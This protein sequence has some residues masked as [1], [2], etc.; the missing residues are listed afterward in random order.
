MTASPADIERAAELLVGGGV[1]AF[2]TE[3]VYGVGA[4]ATDEDAVE[5]IFVMKGRPKTRPLIVH[6]AEADQVDQFASEVPDYARK[7]TSLWPGPLTIVLNRR[8]D[9]LDVVTGGGDTVAVRIP[10]HDVALKMLRRVRELGGPQAGVAAPSAN[11]FGEPPPTSVQGVIDGLGRP[12]V[13][14]VGTPDMILDGGECPGGVPSTIVS[15]VGEWP[16][17]LRYGALDRA[18]IEDCIGRFVDQ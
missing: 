15:C 16:R 2:P 8:P 14:E 6:L 4:I 1:V 12:T 17:I 13:D 11:R 10:D 18:A 5:R 9:V 3:T 7:L